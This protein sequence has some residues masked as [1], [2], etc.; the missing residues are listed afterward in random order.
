MNDEKTGERG[1]GFFIA[2]LD[3]IVFRVKILICAVFA[4]EKILICVIIA[5]VKIAIFVIL[6]V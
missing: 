4:L 5:F 1:A 6:F 2:V 3:F